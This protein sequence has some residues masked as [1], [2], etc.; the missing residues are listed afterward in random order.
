MLSKVEGKMFRKYKFSKCIF[1]LLYSEIKRN[2]SE[3]KILSLLG[4]NFEI[5]DNREPFILFF[6][7]ITYKCFTTKWFIIVSIKN[8]QNFSS[9]VWVAFELHISIYPHQQ[10]QFQA[11]ELS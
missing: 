8:I 3:V 7:N 6:L 4:T 11:S 10:I 1:W 5:K 9:S 2:Y